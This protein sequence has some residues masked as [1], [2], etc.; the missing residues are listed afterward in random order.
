MITSA[1][2]SQ[3]QAILRN[4]TSE[5]E[6]SIGPP[7]LLATFDIALVGCTVVLSC[8]EDE[9]K[10]FGESEPGL[11]QMSAG[12]K[13][14]AVWKDGN[15]KELVA[16]LRSQQ[17]ALNMLIQTLQMYICYVSYRMSRLLIL[18]IGNHYPKSNRFSKSTRPF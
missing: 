18:R 15:I 9:V 7:E 14:K 13:I 3:I 2:L 11:T 6:A 17:S 8:I 12:Q 1:S 5:S 4:S 10:S 16:Q